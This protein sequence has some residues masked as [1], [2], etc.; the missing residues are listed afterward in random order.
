MRTGSRLFTLLFALS[1]AA[2]ATDTT[3]RSAAPTMALVSARE[4]PIEQVMTDSEQPSEVAA[5]EAGRFLGPLAAPGSLGNERMLQMP[6]Y[7]AMLVHRVKD[8]EAWQAAFLQRRDARVAAGFV[9][10]GIMRGADNERLVAVWLAATDVQLAKQYFAD[11]AVRDEWRQGGGDGKPRTML[12]SNVEARMDP[13]RQGLYAALVVIKVR[14]LDAFKI[15]FDAATA[16]R[17]RAGI[18]GFSLGRDIDDPTTAYVYLQSVE[19]ESLRA[20]LA[21][22]ETRQSWKE[23]GLTGAPNVTLIREGELT[24]YQ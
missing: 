23:A 14:D 17:V 10:H 24:T 2:C 5:A 9:A 4:P 8:F 18:V 7:G 11:K 20:Y 12:W 6:M 16:S 19:A 15:A 3:Q 22:K 21:A 13:G 1:A